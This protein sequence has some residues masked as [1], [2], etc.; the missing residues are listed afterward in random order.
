MTST[1]LLGRDEF[2]AC[3]APPMRNV[4]AGA[5][6]VDVQPY[7]DRLNLRDLGISETGEVAYIYRDA[8]ERFDQLLIKTAEPLVFLVIVVDLGA[9]EIL[10]HHL[11]DLEREY[12]VKG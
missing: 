11:L 8:R 4:S 1:R 9:G 10:G 12:G 3:F 2:L 5:A 6:A 7:V